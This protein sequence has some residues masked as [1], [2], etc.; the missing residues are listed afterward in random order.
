[1]LY[2]IYKEKRTY[3]E[4]EKIA[5]NMVNAIVSGEDKRF[6]DNPGFDVI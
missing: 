6:W 1:M 2:N 4:Y 3:I 5:P